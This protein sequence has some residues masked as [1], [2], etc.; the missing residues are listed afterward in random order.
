MKGSDL[1]AEMFGAADSVKQPHLDRIRALGVTPATIAWLGSWSVPFGVVSATTEASGI[2]QPGDGP[3][4]ILQPVFDNGNLIDL[5][6]WHSMR[7]ERWW[8]RTGVAWALNVD[9][10]AAIDRWGGDALHLHASPLD[11]LKNGATGAVVLD[12]SAPEV[13]TLRQHD[14]IECST[15]AL[16]ATLTH[17]LQ[18]SVHMPAIETKENR[19]AA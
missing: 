16:A 1:E 14:R 18:T 17:A 10:I 2:Y 19:L 6:I 9:D 7:P 15:P 13:A 12:W 3:A 11:W 5:V 8:T 4:H